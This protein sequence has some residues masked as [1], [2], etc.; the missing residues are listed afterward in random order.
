MR[1][2]KGKEDR[3]ERT[4]IRVAPCCRECQRKKG[5]VECVRPER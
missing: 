5:H 2:W 1:T 3:Y 4:M